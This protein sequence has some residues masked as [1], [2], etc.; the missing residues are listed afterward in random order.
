MGIGGKNLSESCTDV[1]GPRQEAKCVVKDMPSQHKYGKKKQ[2]VKNDED[3]Y[4]D[5]Y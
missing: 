3:K 2:F 5:V 1:K 4:L